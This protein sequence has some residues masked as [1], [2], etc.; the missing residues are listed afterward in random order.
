MKAKERPR[1]ELAAAR[2]PLL[3]IS[4]TAYLP[5]A[6]G[7]GRTFAFILKTYCKCLLSSISFLKTLPFHSAA[8]NR[9]KRSRTPL[10]LLTEKNQISAREAEQ[11]A[12]HVSARLFL[13]LRSKAAPLNSVPGI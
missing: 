12:N 3:L 7:G 11:R 13:L 1:L 5:I 8:Y 6:R 10:H 9:I 2:Y 4:K